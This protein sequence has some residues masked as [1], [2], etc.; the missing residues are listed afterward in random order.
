MPNY[1]ENEEALLKKLGER[2]RAGFKIVYPPSERARSAVREEIKKQWNEKR[3][4]DQNEERAS[5]SQKESK[6]QSK[7]QSHGH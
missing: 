7:G 2:L 5:E 6:N 3:Q 4:K 1:E